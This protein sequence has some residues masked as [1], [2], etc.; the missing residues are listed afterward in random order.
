MMSND[1]NVLLQSVLDMDRQERLRTQ[2]AEEYR[3]KAMAKLEQDRKTIHEKHQ[4]LAKQRIEE[5]ARTQQ[6]HEQELLEQMKQ[7]SEAVKQELTTAYA[8]KQQEWVKTIF[9]RVLER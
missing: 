1:T 3:G 2:E 6:L 5:Y 7:K 4:Q 9:A 8:A